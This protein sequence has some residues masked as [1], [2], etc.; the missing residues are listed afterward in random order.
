M[1]QQSSPFAQVRVSRDTTWC[2]TFDPTT[3]IT[4][5]KVIRAEVVLSSKA[6]HVVW[7]ASQAP[8]PST[9]RIFYRRGVFKTTDVRDDPSIA[10]QAVRLHQNYPNPF[11]SMTV[12]S[13]ELRVK[14]GVRLVVYDLLGREVATLVDEMQDAR[15][16]DVVGQ[17]GFRS[18]QWD[19]SGMASGVYYYKLLAGDR[20][21]TKKA[22]LIR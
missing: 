16:N 3:G 22:V 19:A 9:F 15:L 1:D 17:A 13:Y 20:V 11:N 12:M 7:E 4:T 14:S 21:E 10:P 18:V 6:V 8:S 2:S 5:R